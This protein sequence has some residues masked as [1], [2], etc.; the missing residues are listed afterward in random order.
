[1]LEKA[2]YGYYGDSTLDS[3]VEELHKELSVSS[4]LFEFDPCAAYLS[5]C[6]ESRFHIRD[7]IVLTEEF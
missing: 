2:E 6:L 5:V 4:Y 3:G 1:M 7:C